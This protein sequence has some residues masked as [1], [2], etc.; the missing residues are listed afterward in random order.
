[1]KVDVVKEKDINKHLE[2]FKITK[3]ITSQSVIDM[4]Y[5]I[6]ICEYF[7]NRLVNYSQNDRNYIMKQLEECIPNK[8]EIQTD[9]DIE[10]LVKYISMKAKHRD[11]EFEEK[12]LVTYIKGL[13]IYIKK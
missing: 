1:M 10:V 5:N 8:I 4:F 12:E 3:K 2:D 7:Q 6:K 9:T 11:I 13:S